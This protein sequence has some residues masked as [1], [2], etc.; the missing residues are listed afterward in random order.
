[1]T[2]WVSAVTH[3]HRS[4]DRG[5][6]WRHVARIDG[7]FWSSL[8]VH[9]GAAYLLGTEH[10]HGRIMI[11]RSDDGG[12]T[13]THPTDTDHGLLTPEGEYHTAPMPVIVHDGR[14]W[15]A[16]EDASGGDKWG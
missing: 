14:L 16:M 1:S 2:E 4:D 6:T 9:H 10:H 13:W 15:R 8:F 11:R 12:R 5:K 7:L 3:V